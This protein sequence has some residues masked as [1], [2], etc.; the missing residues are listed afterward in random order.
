M[1]KAELIKAGDKRLLING[2]PPKVDCRVVAEDNYQ[3][4][5]ETLKEIRAWDIQNY[6]NGNGVLMPQT[7][8]QKI[9]IFLEQHD[10]G[11]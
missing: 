11:E 2:V 10:E 8:R 1:T 9:Q 4:I 3:E 6:V 5:L 7:I